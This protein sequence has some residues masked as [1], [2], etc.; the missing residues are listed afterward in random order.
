MAQTAT[1][2]PAKITAG[3][4]ISWRI[5]L[6]D[7]P[8]SEGWV[9]HYRLINAAGKIDIDAVA[10]G[11]AYRVAVAAS[12]SAGYAAGRYDWQSYVTRTTER[13]TVAVGAMT[14]APNLAA[15]AAGYDTRSTVRKLFDAVEA[16]LLNRA[17]RTDL[18][19]EIAGRRIKSMSHADLIAARSK[20][21][22]ELMREEAEARIAAGQSP[23]RKILTRFG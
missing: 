12:I 18:E 2:E 15:E 16:A 20:L 9:L 23:R 17:S 1:T 7:F 6:P 13:Y 11:D 10:D 21:R 3:D 22:A 4:S 14:V 5:D 8:A 19:Y